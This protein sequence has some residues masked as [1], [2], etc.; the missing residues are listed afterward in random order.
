MG[1]LMQLL[2]VC[3]RMEEEKELVNITSNTVPVM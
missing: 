3:V 2:T 1:M